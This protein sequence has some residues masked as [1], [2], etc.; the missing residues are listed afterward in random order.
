ME[1]VSPFF[2]F[3]FLLKFLF[4]FICDFGSQKEES[5]P[6]DGSTDS[7]NLAAVLTESRVDA[8]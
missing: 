4:S 1:L 5:I 8:F 6:E 3:F 2:F 7:P